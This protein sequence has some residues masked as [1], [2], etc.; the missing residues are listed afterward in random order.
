MACLGMAA[1]MQR[2]GHDVSVYTTNFGTPEENRVPFDEPVL[3][4]GVPVRYYPIHFPKRWET[5][6]PLGRA[7]DRAV[8]AVDIVH[9]HSLYMYHDMA[10]AAACRRHGVPYVIMP[11][12]ALDPFIWH[13]SRG[14]KAI[15][16]RI[17]QNRAL[18]RAAA[19][20]YTTEDERRLAQPYARNPRAIV[21]GNG[22][23]P[24]EFDSLPPPGTF[25]AMHPEIGDRPI[26]LFLGRLNFKKGL[27]LLAPAFG[28]V[29][30]AGHDAHLVIAGGDE[31]MA[32]KTRGWL[33]DAG[34]LERTSFTGMI[35]G[36]ERLAALADASMF[37]LPSYSENFGIAVAE[38]MLCRLPVVISDQVNIWEEVAAAGAGLVSGCEVG[39]VADNIA[40]LLAD[41]VRAH[42]MGEA[43]RALVLEKY[44]W[45]GIAPALEKAYENV[46]TGRIGGESRA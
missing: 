8:P 36:A 41:P 12:G 5:S 17:F 27:D 39:P 20:H 15:F 26:V 37:V 13:H 21:V 23:D 34:A 18:E 44:S 4:N 7:L 11:H 19:I 29:L 35:S 24:A 10:A 1:A 32:E 16:E 14:R 38:A 2:R 9:L 22:V 46:V 31:D 42:A 6:L 25:R 3:R 40:S 33:R 28:R 30:A 45:D 43:G